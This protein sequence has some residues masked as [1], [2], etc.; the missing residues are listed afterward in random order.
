MHTMKSLTAILLA[1]ALLLSLA[2]CGSQPSPTQAPGTA[3]TQSTAPGPKKVQAAD[4]LEAFT[5]QP[6]AE[7][8]ADEA[9]IRAGIDWAVRLFKETYAQEK[10][11]KTL[12]VSPLSVM[13]ALSMTANGAKNNTLA[14]MEKALGGEIKLEDLN[15]YLH[16]YLNTL[17]SSEKA[18]FSFAN[19]IW[20]KDQADF[21]VKDAFLQKNVDYFKAAIRKA[22]FDDSTLQ[23]INQWVDQHTDHMIPKLLNQLKKEDRML[24]VNALVFDAKWADPFKEAY[25]WEA[26]FTNLNGQENLATYMSG[27]VYSYLEDEEAVGFVKDYEGGAYRFAAL[28]PKDEKGFE[29]YI[30]A[31][32]GEKISNLLK[33]ETAVKVHISLPK[34][35]YDYDIS[36]NDTL[37]ALG[38][39][40]AFNAEKADLSGIC[41]D[42]P[43]FISNVI[44]KTHIDL[45][46]EGTRAAAVTAVMV[47]EATAMIEEW[48]EVYL[49]RPFVYMIVDS[50]TNL[51]IFMGTVTD[52]GR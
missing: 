13:T 42:T 16:T 31:L 7:K 22:P 11:N 40:E 37:M 10:D 27:E 41:A 5:P 3:S 17:P 52:F 38:I 21:V 23:E 33:N 47:A 35:S 24:L 26:V 14:E 1:A 15:A 44:H 30:S 28:L 2:A 29:S 50:A 19:G 49:D 36:L 18:K 8:K 6:V 20:F 25:C 34:F 45:D 12:L 48:K 9:F 51:P 4:L 39:K 46:S 43:L 32:T